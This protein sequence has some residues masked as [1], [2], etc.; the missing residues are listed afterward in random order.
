MIK[1]NENEIIIFPRKAK[2]LASM[3]MLKKMR[4]Q[5]RTGKNCRIVGL[6]DLLHAAQTVLPA[7]RQKPNIENQADLIAR[8]KDRILSV[9]V[10]GVNLTASKVAAPK[11]KKAK[12]PKAKSKAELL[13]ALRNIENQLKAISQS[14]A[15]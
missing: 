12:A 6:T 7:A 10:H 15:A 4:S 5:V 1:W 3:E 9:K 2:S 14:V 13:V 8:L 11:A